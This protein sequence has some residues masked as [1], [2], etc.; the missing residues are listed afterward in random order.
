MTP[1]SGNKTK[2]LIQVYGD[3]L[4]MP[5][6]EDSI[7]HA[8]V[9]PELLR[10]LIETAHSKNR[11]SIYNR[12]SGGASIDA[13]H[14]R[15]IQDSV[16]FGNEDRRILVIQCGIVDCAPRPVPPKVKTMISRLPL[17]LRWA[18]AKFLHLARPVLLRAGFR[19][20][21][22]E[23]ES[24]SATL[25]KWLRRAMRA[26][27]RIYVIN[28]APTISTTAA[29]SPGLAASIN[30]YN[31]AIAKVVTNA[32]SAMIVLV[33]VNAAIQDAAS[34]EYVNSVDGHHI[35]ASAHRLYAKMIYALEADDLRT[36]ANGG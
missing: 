8:D 13:L 27:D 24:F 19:W 36:L 22:T 32:A 18:V 31:Q 17:P 28:I 35:T 5:R 26:C 20:R 34:A 15:Y 12:S 29:H 14:E 11:V 6:S 2:L 30:D 33:D 7:Y 16:Y 23:I 10:D 3:S 1:N 25:E 21:T 9:Y 4:S